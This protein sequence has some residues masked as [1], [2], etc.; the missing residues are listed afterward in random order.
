MFLHYLVNRPKTDLISQVL[1]AQ[2]EE[3]IKNDWY[4]SVMKD[5]EDFGLDYLDL[6]DIRCMKKDP[7]KKLVKE[8]CQDIALKYLLED[9][10]GK[11]KLKN[12]KYYQLS[13]Q[14]YLQSDQI[15][16]RQKKYLFRFRTRMIKV[17]HNYGNKSVCLFKCFSI[18]LN[19]SQVFHMN[20]E[21]YEDIYR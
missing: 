14:P 18:K 1:H 16:T 8:K 19:S 20:E 2:K 17:N 11:S 4:S 6:E 5:L 21:K 10:E 15:T 7:F 13:M 9:N 3:P 12:L